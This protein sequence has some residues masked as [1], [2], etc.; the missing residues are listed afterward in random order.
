MK[1]GEKFGIG[2]SVLVSLGVMVGLFYW[3]GNLSNQV[4][5]NTANI[6][7]LEHKFDHKFEK[8][9]AKIDAKFDVLYQKIGT[10]SEQLAY[11]S[12]KVGKLTAH[13]SPLRITKNGQQWAR[14]INATRLIDQNEIWSKILNDINAQGIDKESSL[15]E[16]Q[17]ACFRVGNHFEKFIE[18]E[19]LK[20][21][22]YFA[23]NHGYK[24][25]QFGPI[26][27]VLIRDK[28]FKEHNIAVK[29]N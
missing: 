6:E 2:A 17:E 28:Y 19:A 5:V 24:L 18:K 26:L 27:G 29:K 11:I 25:F 3:G 20:K 4:S 12:G 23:F 13:H 9:E 15:Y 22:E 14:V 16:I 7:R 21:L 1:T 10:M 8:L